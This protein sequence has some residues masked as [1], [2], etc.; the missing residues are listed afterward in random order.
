MMLGAG[1]AFMTIFGCRPP[2]PPVPNCGSYILNPQVE[3]LSPGNPHE[4]LRFPKTDGHQGAI[5]CTLGDSEHPPPPISLT[6][7]PLSRRN[8]ISQQVTVATKGNGWIIPH[9]DNPD[10]T[11]PQ[12]QDSLELDICAF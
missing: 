4:Y 2:A 7:H 11:F 12:V 1:G 6:T 10:P 5:I 8:C 9:V 3:F